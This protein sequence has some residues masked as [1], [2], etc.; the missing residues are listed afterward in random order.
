MNV[1]LFILNYN[2]AGFVGE[3]IHS[4]SEAVK[5]SNYDCRV[6]VIDNK[7]TDESV[8][9]IKK[10][11]PNVHLLLMSQNRVLCSFNNAASQSNADIVF[12]L[13]NDLKA[14]PF[15]IDPMVSVFQENK[16]AFLVTAK[17]LLSDGSYEGGLSIPLMSY[18]MFSTTCHFP[19]Y[20]KLKEESG[21]T[22][23]AGF[24][25]F[26]RQRFLELGGYDDLYLPGRVEDSDLML[27]AWKKGWK[28]YYQP[29]SIF[30]HMGGRSFKQKYG[31]RGTME[32][33]YR[34]SFLFMWKNI[35]SSE[36]VAAH[37]FF[38]F[39]RMIWMLM[40][41]HWEFIAAFL[42]ALTKLNLV[43]DRRAKEKKISY[44]FLD[45]EVITLFANGS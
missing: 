5:N 35:F 29:A 44:R 7:S 12:L 9:F 23:A 39:P 38:L 20:E 21:F 3:C 36:Y 22:F 24:G 26:H 43:I 33:A 16:D 34:N 25:A 41:G 4:F 10:A 18:G 30:Y 13:N 28:C 11:Y 8:A 2:G 19:G 1:D 31:E 42:K 15:S 45:R 27:R 14:D 37:F 32:I 6:V 40:K 17:S